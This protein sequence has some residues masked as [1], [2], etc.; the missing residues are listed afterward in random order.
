MPRPYSRFSIEE[1]EA[2]FDEQGADPYVLSQ[3]VDELA[4]RRSG[5][6]RRLL[7]R[8]A[9]RLASLEPHVEEADQLQGGGALDVDP[10]ALGAVETSPD[11]AWLEGDAPP[12][13]DNV[14][15]ETDS[16]VDD[17]SGNT[18]NEPLPAAHTRLSSIGRARTWTQTGLFGNQAQEFERPPDDLKRPRQL[19][20]MRPPGTPGLPNPWVPPLAQDVS[21]GLPAGTDLPDLYSAALGALVIEIRRTGAGQK[22]YQL[23]N[24]VRVDARTGDTLYSFPF[25]E[26]AELF[27]DAQIEVEIPGHRVSGSIVSISSGQLLLASI[28]SRMAS[29]R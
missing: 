25:T 14:I 16:L 6:A 15:D 22:R 19:S 21:L 26:E 27:V 23:E 17:G 1:L 29:C 11:H 20:R 18:A 2:L 12:D 3:M 4:L 13:F 7:S 9:E 28:K 5:R 24:G 10:A 8:V